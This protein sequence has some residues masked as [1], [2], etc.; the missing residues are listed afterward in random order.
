VFCSYCQGQLFEGDNEALAHLRGRG[1]TDET[2]RRWG[3]GY[4]DR[5][6]WRD[7]GKWGLEG[8]NK[9][10]L[11][12]GV[13]IPWRVDGATWHVKFRRFD[14]D[15]KYIRIRG[16]VP[17]LYGLDHLTDKAAVVICEG[18]LD[19]VLVWQEAGD[20]VDAVAIGAKT[21]RVGAKGIAHLAPA[22]HWLLA[23]DTDAEAE[24]GTWAEYSDRVHRIKPIEGND[25][26]DFH[27]AGGDLRAWIL[28]HHERLVMP[29]YVPELERLLATGLEDPNDR[30][31]YD[32][33]NKRLGG[34]WRAE[35]W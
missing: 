8:G 13:V 4:H 21:A 14:D 27:N 10:F 30:Q 23:L 12:R 3:L 9:I 32:R 24:A 7:P 20:L 28:H 15:P 22:S 33:L 17:A 6:R 1:L 34:L 18:E 5:K 26:T 29:D 19:A 25:L 16:G 2:I 31:I 35:G 11:P